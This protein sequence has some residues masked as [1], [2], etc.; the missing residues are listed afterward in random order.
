M[1]IYLFIEFKK[2]KNVDALNVVY[3]NIKVRKLGFV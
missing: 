3:I 2:N 1:Y